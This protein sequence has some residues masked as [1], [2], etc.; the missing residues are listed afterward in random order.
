MTN[1]ILR[2]TAVAV[3]VLS[4][5]ACS[6][7]DP[8]PANNIT[9]DA[10]AVVT[11]DPR[12]AHPLAVKVSLT[13]D[14]AE[15]NVSVS[16]F[17]ID[18]TEDPN[19]EVRQIPIDTVVL[20]NVAAGT[21]D[22]DMEV[23]IPASVE[24]AGDYYIGVDVDPVEE[25]PELDEEDN[26]ASAEVVLGS[27]VVP[28]IILA[29][30]ELDRLS[31]IIRT[32]SY[33]EQVNAATGDVYN[34]DAGGVI[35]IGADGLELNETVDIETFASL[36]IIRTVNATTH[37]L[38]L[39]LWHSVLQRYTHAYGIDPDTGV[40][41]ATE[42][43]P[44]GTF[45][46]RLSE[47][48]GEEADLDDVV[49]NTEHMDFYIPSRL[50]EV[51]EDELRFPP[52]PP[53][54]GNCTQDN[55]LPPPT[56]PPPDLS[57]QDIDLLRAFF[58]AGD[59]PFSGTPGDES[60]GMAVLD[61]EIC[62]KVRAADPTLIDGIAEDNEICSPIDIFLPPLP[63]GTPL[64]P[65][66]SFQ[67]E[68]GTGNPV[69]ADSSGDG[70]ATKSGNRTFSFDLDFGA[71][72]TADY[73]GYIE[74]VTA[75]IPVRIFGTEFDFMRITARAQ[76]VP[77]YF[78][79]PP[80]EE[81]GFSYEIKFLG[82]V[83]DH[84]PPTTA[85]ISLSLIEVEYSKEVESENQ[86]FVGPVPVV[87][88]ASIGGA[89]GIDYNFGYNDDAAPYMTNDIISNDGAVLRLGS[90]IEPYATLEA[91]AFAGV[92]LKDIF[93]AGVEGV[94][95]LLDERIVLFVGVD[96]DVNNDGFN[97]EPVDFVVR[98][99]LDLSNVFTGPQGHI[100]LFAKYTAPKVST[101]KWKFIKVT[102]IKLGK[103]KV[104][105]NLYSTP[106]LFRRS[107]VLLEFPLS[108]IEVVIVDGQPAYFA[109]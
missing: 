81:S 106:A 108:E 30:S 103:I 6:G 2:A 3:T 77:D 102:C 94:L 78:D 34:A 55:T 10:V 72:A 74:E 17:A 26:L 48:V 33:E 23:V 58:R 101:C 13:A 70:F 14:R 87:V 12:I 89:I 52:P 11:A 53:C 68:F 31:L 59:L 25:I 19:A 107:D 104:T 27:S 29:N 39:Y 49:R 85:S 76:L 90:S 47:I 22:Y 62:V 95:T 82:G 21:N 24:F 98:Q 86:L 46:P 56:I 61:F 69:Q 66:G 88:G 1:N 40:S 28:N 71:T 54:T 96:I 41:V 42:W 37:E 60:A 35:T 51:M 36:R 100:N 73:R 57:A 50:G 43:L 80:S 4:L 15:K 9:A 7:G 67:P 20:D 32:E 18:R 92:G 97:N 65:I 105:K 8:T 109:P 5:N 79:K 16:L 91:L 38:P 63:A 45:T 84:L 75:G 93:V 99:L 83:I 44:M 64:Y